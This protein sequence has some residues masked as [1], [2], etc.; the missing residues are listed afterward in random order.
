M[1]LTTTSTSGR[2]PVGRS[3]PAPRRTWI[4]TVFGVLVLAVMLFPVYWLVNS[5]LQPFGSTL[6]G[7]VFPW[8]PDTSGY[9]RAISEQGRNLLTSLVIAL[10]TVVVVLVVATPAAYALAQFRFRWTQAALLVVLVTQMIPSIIIAG[11][12]YTAY[13]G[14]HLLNTVPGLV[15]A[16]ASL[17]VP[18]AVLVLYPAFTGIPTSI[19]EA[20]RIDGAGLVRTF[21]SIVVP[22]SRNGII[23]A[24]LFSF[25]FA[26]GD[27][28]FALTLT[29]D[30]SV[31][32]ITLGIYNYLGT[33]V[34][35]WSAVMA[36]GVLASI[37]AIVLL[38]LAQ[39][40]IT[41]GAMGGSVK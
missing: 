35:S 12:A 3:R 39:K 36:T 19:I 31:R 21:R 8:H 13:S 32:P 34:S 40:Y 20:A 6:S 22:V 27:F 5:S 14:L 29:T 25:L 38:L 7:A 18:F 2:R 24:G 26:W 11:A 16:D 30:P 17:G 33:N 41:A 1:T 23:T 15:L 9:A 28:L 4:S 37:P 10:L